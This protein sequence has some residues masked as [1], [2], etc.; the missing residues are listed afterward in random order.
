MAF[1]LQGFQQTFKEN[2][3]M[4]DSIG[5]INIAIGR[6]CYDEMQPI[7]GRLINYYDALIENSPTLEDLPPL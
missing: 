5:K 1:D 6:C 3:D 7:L 4:A 2:G